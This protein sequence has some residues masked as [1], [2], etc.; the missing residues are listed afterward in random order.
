MK[1][2][3]GVFHKSKQQAIVKQSNSNY[4]KLQVL[5]F[6]FGTKELSQNNKITNFKLKTVIPLTNQRSLQLQYYKNP[7]KNENK[8]VC[9]KTF[10]QI[11]FVPLTK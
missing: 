6:P 4:L 3:Y 1:F 5:E 11:L 7:L 8:I 2:S 9:S 10:Y